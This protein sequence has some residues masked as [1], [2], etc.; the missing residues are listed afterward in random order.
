MK[1][2]FW[3]VLSGTIATA[4]LIPPAPARAQQAQASLLDLHHTA[5]GEREGLRIGA[6]SRLAR[7]PDGYL[8]LGSP[9][10]LI[11]FDGIRFVTMDSTEAPQMVSLV[12]GDTRPLLVDRNG[13]LWVAR[14]DGALVQYKNGMFRQVLAPDTSRGPMYR[15]VED[16]GGGLWFIGRRELHTWRDDRLQRPALPAGVPDTGVIGVIPDTGAGVWIGTYAGGF[17]HLVAG[18]ARHYRNPGSSFDDAVRPL[19]QD[20]DGTLW[21][22]GDGLQSL[23]GD[24]WSRRDLGRIRIA[25][26]DMK[27]APDGSLWIATRGQGV[28]RLQGHSL[29]SFTEDNGLTDAVTEEILIDQEGSIWASTDAGLDRFR[30]APFSVIDRRNGLP[31]QSP[32]TIL[33][34]SDGSIWAAE[35]GRRRVFHLDGGIV[36]GKPGPVSATLVSTAAG[37][38]PVGSARPDG[39]W[40]AGFNSGDL[41][42][43]S[44]GRHGPVL[45]DPARG[46]PA[47]RRVFED[48]RGNVWIL[49]YGSGFGRLKDGRYLPIALP[50]ESTQ[51]WVFSLTEDG[52][53][54]LWISLAEHPVLYELRDG[55]VVTRLDAA[56]GLPGEIVGLA[57]QGSDTIWATTG[58]GILLRIVGGDIDTLAIP[59]VARVM[60]LSSAT[61]IGD[62]HD[63]WFASEDGLGKI[64]L[65]TL[66][67]RMDGQPIDVVPRFFDAL[68]GVPVGKMTR[69]NSAPAFKALD[70]RIWFATP[71][72]IAVVNPKV[73][74][75]NAV[76]PI[77]HIEEASVAGLR[78]PL[79][80]T[81]SIGPNPERLEFRYTATGLR[82]PERMR[83][84]YQLQGAD[85]D[86]VEG[87]AAR[88]ATYTQL[89]PGNYRF[90]VRAWNEDG[91]PS[92]SEAS[93]AI[94]V[95]PTWYEAWW[96]RLGLVLALLIGGAGSLAAWL[97]AR[98]RVKV[99]RLQ[100]AFD[101]ALAERTRLARDLHDTLLQGFT[102]ITLQIQAARHS[103][104]HSPVEADATLARVLDTAD[105]TLRD[106]RLMVWD[107]RAPELG[108]QEL[109]QALESAART[110]IAGLD[111][112]L[113]VVVAGS[114]RRLSLSSETAALRIAREAVVNAVKHAAP[115]RI[116]VELVYEERLLR[117]SVR[118]DGRGF[119]PG[120]EH[121]AAGGG[122]WGIKGM[123]ERATRAGGTL[124]ITG[125]AGKGTTLS[126]NLPVE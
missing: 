81:L 5:W 96:F 39:V 104:A 84:Q 33:G 91:V 28:L 18:R 8:W 7:T 122:H 77:V 114:P 89:R 58:Q 46:D 92:P 22:W 45:L 59:A 103:L 82:V 86:W 35:A 107:M 42:R 68:D 113:E 49:P 6:A 93:I 100:A 63:L 60:S 30:A 98:S 111:I 126:L 88:T 54:H 19:L 99:E 102:G 80:S 112:E 57:A 78:I 115:S 55:R 119:P 52:R 66:N 38:V 51:S 95:M 1:F 3:F 72:G 37:D 71:G 117:L 32:R 10:G 109:P 94:R 90:R 26:G 43:F 64:P 61:I 83:L 12:S 11:R 14:P 56:S 106:A 53:G 25:A 36:R 110:S 34:A 101:A 50:G 85:G 69:Q 15:M 75:T 40:L 4:V 31:F 116:G 44:D 24:Q 65:A 74:A 27:Q 123:R 67:A 62:E 87:N 9:N 76:P 41:H 23:R 21:V 105:T 79:A 121:L 125:A 124:E 16:R 118:D 17:W 70:G 97:R 47:V 29:E 48:S 13:V 108:H 2:S 20:R 120:A 73:V